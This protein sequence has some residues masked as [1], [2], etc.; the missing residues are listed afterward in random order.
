MSTA[1][2]VPLGAV[3]LVQRRTLGRSFFLT[4]TPQVNEIVRYALACSLRGLGV[5]MHAFSFMS[6]R[7]MLVVTDTRSELP[8]LM[9]RLDSMIARAVNRALG[10]RGQFWMKEQYSAVQLLDDDAALDKCAHVWSKPVLTGLVRRGWH[11][12][13]ATSCDVRDGTQIV[14]RRPNAF[15][16]RRL[17]RELNFTLELPRVDGC[18]A[19][20]VYM[21][22]RE[23]AWKLTS[24]AETN[25]EVLGMRRVLKQ[26]PFEAP[27]SNE[28]PATGEPRFA[29]AACLCAEARRRRGLWLNEYR[30][31]LEVLRKKLGVVVFPAGT[32]LMRV[33]YGYACVPP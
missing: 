2:E 5:R 27:P 13:G 8:K 7:L 30:A 31:K 33:R 11:W 29:G 10:R 3:Y 17:P 19:S 1:R 21:S 15:F 32:Y 23:R 25:G 18:D 4:P 26:S 24:G 14:A 9:E 22:I 6:N 20:D 28:S 12:G 16:S